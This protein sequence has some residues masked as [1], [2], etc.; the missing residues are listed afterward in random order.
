[1]TRSGLPAAIVTA[2]WCLAAP[3]LHAQVTTGTIVGTIADASGIVPG[4]A[5][6]VREMNKGTATTYVTDETGSYT[7]PFLV[8]G[9][10]AVSH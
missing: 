9:T 5:V 10:Y 8:P 7:A 2:L 3:S 6:I 1:M 4:A